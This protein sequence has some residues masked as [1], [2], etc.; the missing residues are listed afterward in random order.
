L[1]DLRSCVGSYTLEQGDIKFKLPCITQDARDVRAMGYLLREK[2]LKKWSQPK[3]R[4]FVTV[5]KD[6]RSWKY[7]STLISDMDMQS[8]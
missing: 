6:E 3:G 7:E 4:K 8:L 5:N 2:L 1:E